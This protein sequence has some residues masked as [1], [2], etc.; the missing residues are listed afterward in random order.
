MKA[1]KAVA[2]YTHPEFL[3][4]KTAPYEAWVKCGGLTAKPHYPWRPFHGLAYR[5]ELPTLHISKG[6]VRLR[7]VQPVSIKFD[8]FPDYALY[9][10]IPLFWDVWPDYW[11]KTYNWLEKHHIKTA[12]FTSS[13]V[14]KLVKERFP[15]MNVLAITEGI[16]VKSYDEGMILHERTIDFL[17]YG[18]N[19]DRVVRYHFDNMNVV[20]GQKDRKNLLT[21]EEL[22]SSLQNAKIVAAYPKNWTNPKQAG[23]IETLTQRYWEG[24]LSRC[25][26]IGHA[27]QELIDLIGYNPVIEVDLNNP[28]KQLG[29]IVNNIDNYQEWVDNN[30]DTALKLGD[31][32]VRMSEIRE[33]LC[34]L[35][36]DF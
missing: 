24:M 14:A 10:V 18:R 23:D 35:G 6:E 1:I 32:T 20:R 16:D 13:H 5:W 4:F 30:R 9:E 3:N 17:E 21:P 29:N 2:P 11:E 27:P 19:I 31:W 22:R 33:W 7:F 28:D 36:Y 25:V 34:S 8:T 15:S 12:I 26:M